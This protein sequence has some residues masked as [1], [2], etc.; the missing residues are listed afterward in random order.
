MQG[1]CY[2]TD[3][4]FFVFPSCVYIAKFFFKKGWFGDILFGR[5]FY[6]AKVPVTKH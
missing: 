2:E 1:V 5:G 3:H 4:L 6:I